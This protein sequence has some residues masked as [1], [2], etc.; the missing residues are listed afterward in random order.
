MLDK[1]IEEKKSLLQ[2]ISLLMAIGAIF[3]TIQPS[4]DTL[5]NKALMNLQLLWFLLIFS[6]ILILFYNIISFFQNTQFAMST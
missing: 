3:L 5:V 2:T 1:F 6:S 4:E